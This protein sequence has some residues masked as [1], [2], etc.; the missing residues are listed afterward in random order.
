MGSL[1]TVHVN[2]SKQV[3][4]K[5]KANFFMFFVSIILQSLYHLIPTIIIDLSS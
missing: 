1:Q 2:Q 3:Q 4:S 5:Y